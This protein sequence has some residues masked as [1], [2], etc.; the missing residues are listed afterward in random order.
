MIDAQGTAPRTHP[1]D[2]VELSAVSIEDG[3]MDRPVT[4]RVR[5]K[6]RISRRGHKVHGISNADV[7]L[8]P[9][10]AAVAEA[11]RT[12]FGDAI[13]VGH[14]V[15]TS[16]GV[17]ARKLPDWRPVEALDT[18]RLVLSTLDIRERRLSVLAEH[19]GLTGNI[20]EHLRPQGATWN[21]LVTARLFVHLANNFGRQW[22]VSE[23]R[24]RGQWLCPHPVSRMQLLGERLTQ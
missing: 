7:A 1:P 9:P 2:L 6:E 22:T 12:Y 13:P 16:L 11:V 8:C 21:A 14:N 18:L 24:E 15:R 17:M 19:L 4:W 10:F 20:P 3:I 23:L 5:P